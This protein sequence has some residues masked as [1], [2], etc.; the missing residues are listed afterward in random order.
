MQLAMQMKACLSA[1]RDC[2]A[3]GGA[4]KY[5]S[6]YQNKKTENRNQPSEISHQKSDI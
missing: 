4:I 2:D 6:W 1:V 3:T 5:N